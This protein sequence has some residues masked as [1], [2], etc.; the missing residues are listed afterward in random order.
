MINL[1]HGCYQDVLQDLMPDA[2]I[3]D[4]PYSGRTHEGRRTGS[5]IST[6]NIQYPPITREDAVELAEFWSPRVK[7]WAVIFGDHVSW[8]WHEEAWS[9]VGWYTF[10]PVLWVKPNTA[11]RMSGDGPTSST[12]NILVARRKQTLPPERTGSRPGHYL[13]QTEKGGDINTITGLSYPG[14][15]PLKLMRQIISDYTIEGDIVCDSH[16]GTGSTLIAAA[17][18]GRVA[19]GAEQDQITYELAKSRIDGN[20]K[21]NHSYLKTITDMFA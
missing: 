4:P 20:N 21:P 1:Q 8:Q 19:E 6:S 15:K 11:P 16:A 13:C 5:E 14:R 10:A 3:C 7:W 18:L 2:L 9:R 17:Q 12:E